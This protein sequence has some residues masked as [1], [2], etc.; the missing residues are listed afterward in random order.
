MVKI[1]VRSPP[2]RFK[3]YVF[4]GLYILVLILYILLLKHAFYGLK[5]N[6]KLT[7]V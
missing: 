6:H 1:I 3:E 4:L 7:S 2:T 5:L